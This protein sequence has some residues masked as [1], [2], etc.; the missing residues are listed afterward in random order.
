MFLNDL[1]L[2]VL[3]D[4]PWNTDDTDCPS[5]KAKSQ[6]NSERFMAQIKRESL[7]WM[8]IS[9]PYSWF[10]SFAARSRLIEYEFD[11]DILRFKILRLATQI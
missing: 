10:N 8:P 3:V 4:V 5:K 11:I 6:E 7:G 9:L 1:K 2:V